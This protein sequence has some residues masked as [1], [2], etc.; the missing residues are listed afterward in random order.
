MK[1]KK[2]RLLDSSKDASVLGS[3]N[4]APIEQNDVQLDFDG[5]KTGTSFNV[6]NALNAIK[7]VKQKKSDS[8]KKKM[9][10]NDDEL[11]SFNIDA[12][13]LK[14]DDDQD[15]NQYKMAE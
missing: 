1:N 11:G 6:N 3:N 12:D 10:E 5:N 2:N 15:L 7:N 4:Q 9:L 13:Q 14:I 8:S